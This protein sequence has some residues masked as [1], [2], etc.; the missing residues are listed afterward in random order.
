MTSY[1]YLVMKNI[2][3]ESIVLLSSERRTS[4][5][6]YIARQVMQL[7]KSEDG[8]T[9]FLFCSH[10]N[11]LR[12]GRLF[13]I[14]SIYKYKYLASLFSSSA[15]I[16]ILSVQKYMR[17]VFTAVHVKHYFCVLL[18]LRQH[19]PGPLDWLW[20]RTNFCLGSTWD[21]VLKFFFL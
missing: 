21:F 2:Y 10:L 12:T 17:R 3:N 16:Y 13:F 15:A 8:G 20:L 7:T 9:L 4:S 14:S 11:S 5:I 1:T 18:K 19:L 6:W